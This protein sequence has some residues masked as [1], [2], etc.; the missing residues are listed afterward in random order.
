MTFGVSACKQT[1][2]DTKRPSPKGLR[3]FPE[4][5][6]YLTLVSCLNLGS[7]LRFVLMAKPVIEIEKTPNESNSSVLRRFSRR[8]RG[9]GIIKKAKSLR[10]EE[11]ALSPFKK[12]KSKLVRMAKK[13]E[14]DRMKK[15]GK[16]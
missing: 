2:Q 12:K 4:R 5:C 13:A 9:S 14:I 15:L 6:V 7:M 1:K 3:E 16:V 8:V 11:R 10:Y